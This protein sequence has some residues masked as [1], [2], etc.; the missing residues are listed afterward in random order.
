[1]LFMYTYMYVPS[2]LLTV[3]DKGI[4]QLGKSGPIYYRIPSYIKLY[5]EIL[6]ICSVYPCTV[7]DYLV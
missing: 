7:S 4:N 5:T 3:C 2:C 1:M 6:D